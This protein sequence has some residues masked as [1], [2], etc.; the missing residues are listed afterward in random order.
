VLGPILDRGAVGPNTTLVVLAAAPVFD[1]DDWIGQPELRGAVFVRCGTRDVSGGRLPESPPAADAL[2]QRV[3]NPVVAVELAGRGVMPFW[4]DNP[5]F[6][7]DGTRLTARDVADF[8][9]TVGFLCGFADAPRALAAQ[10]GAERRTLALAPGRTPTAP[11]WQPLPA[12]ETRVFRQCVI[13]REYTCLACGGAHPAAQL[14]CTGEGGPFIYPALEGL[15]AVGFT[16]FRD[17]G[18][19]VDYCHHACAALRIADDAVAV[20]NGAGASLFR[21]EP[22]RGAWRDAG[23]PLAPY[24]PLDKETHALVL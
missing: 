3:D 14:A 8:S 4:W 17:S 18:R 19:Q 6:H 20:R 9:L 24:H 23:T 21:F 15:R 13:R 22:A 16:L 10:R 11:H 12:R 7:W 1:L 5:A 2:L